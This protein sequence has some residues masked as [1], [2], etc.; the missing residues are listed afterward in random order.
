MPIGVIINAL[1]VV[2][3]GILGALVGHKLSPKFKAD[4]T[5]VFGVCSMGMGIST[6]GLM[7]N[8]PAVIF[9]IVIGTGIGLA[10]HLGE[11][12]NAGAGVMQRAISKFIKN[13]NSELSEDEFM[14]TLVTIIVLFCASGT[15]IYG[16]LVLGMANDSSILLSKAILDFF[17][18]MIFACNLGLVVSYIAIP[19]F[20]IMFILFFALCR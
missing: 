5:L 20:I 7:E 6:I 19:Q 3:G 10:I 12:I 18:A 14:N 9:S 15:G 1:S 11:K 8:M 16:S 17:T 13:S 4:I 2:I